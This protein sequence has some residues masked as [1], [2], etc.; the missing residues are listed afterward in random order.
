[1]QHTANDDV[2]SMLN[3]LIETARDG[4]EGFRNAA[5]N[6]RDAELKRLFMDHSRERSQFVS[7][8]QAVVRQLGGDPERSGSVAA[9]LHRGWMTV[10]SAVTGGDDA[11]ILGAA[12]TGEDSAV[13]AYE[14]ALAAAPP[15]SVR[16]VVEKQARRVREVHDRV[17]T[18]RDT[19]RAA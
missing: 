3:K 13:K 11:A 5:E 12:E 18:L 4:E 17:R 10:K 6:V 8:L 1:M 16:A 14:E 15:E 7:E 2:I 19:R 9:S